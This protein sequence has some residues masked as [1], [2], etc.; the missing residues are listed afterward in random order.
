MLVNFAEYL[1]GD[2]RKN[3]ANY[4]DIHTGV[5]FENGA[6]SSREIYAEQKAKGAA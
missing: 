6:V 3:T 5:F 2:Y 4:R 1:G